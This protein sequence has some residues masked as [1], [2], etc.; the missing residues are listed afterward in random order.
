MGR[1]GEGSGAQ[2][3]ETRRLPPKTHTQTHTDRH[4]HAERLPRA[5]SE[6]RIAVTGAGSPP[7]PG[8]SARSAGRVRIREPP[9]R[10]RRLPPSTQPRNPSSCAGPGKKPRG[11][12]APRRPRPTRRRPPADSCS[13]G[14]PLAAPEPPT[15]RGAPRQP[16]VP[17][18]SVLASRPGRGR[19]GHGAVTSRGGGPGRGPAHGRSPPPRP[20]S[21]PRCGA[22]RP[23]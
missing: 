16:R 3:A 8:E 22:G 9:A 7:H 11:P 4:T 5:G 2:T 23:W 19:R 6:A 14:T 18:D 13:P 15:T 17:S 10:P 20:A 21:R 12:R 1:A